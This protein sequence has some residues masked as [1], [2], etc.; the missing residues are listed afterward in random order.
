MPNSVDDVRFRI[1]RVREYDGVSVP[2]L[3]PLTSRWPGLDNSPG[4][5]GFVEVSGGVALVRLRSNGRRGVGRRIGGPS[6][7]ILQI[8]DR[9]VWS[10]TSV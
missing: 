2:L 5:L 10:F 3:P 7:G 6:E 1:D 4:G 8:E 9:M